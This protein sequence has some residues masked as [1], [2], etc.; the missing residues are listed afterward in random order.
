[1]SL[2]AR[3]LAAHGSA[4]RA[5]R[6]RSRRI[7]R[8]AVAP[9]AR[10]RGIGLAL[11]AR[12]AEQAAG[13]GRDFLSVSFGYTAALWHFWQRAGFHLVRMGTHREASSSL[14]SA[15]ALLPLSDAG[16]KLTLRAAKGFERDCRLAA[17]NGGGRCALNA[18]LETDLSAAGVLKPGALWLFRPVV[19]LIPLRV[20]VPMR[21]QLGAFFQIACGIHPA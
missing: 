15:M 13:E 10:R 14:Y 1:G 11:I 2:V 7:S 19:F 18:P 6:L 3:S 9:T 5:P 12:A 4:W 8:I 20:I 21:R 16:H 17:G